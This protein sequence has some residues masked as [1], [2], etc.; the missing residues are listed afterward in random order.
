MSSLMEASV[1]L[2]APAAVR[3]GKELSVLAGWSPRPAWKV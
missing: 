2:H 3:T 1:H